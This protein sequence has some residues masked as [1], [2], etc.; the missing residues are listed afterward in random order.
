M[1]IRDFREYDRAACLA[2]FDSNVPAYFLTDERD[3]FADFLTSPMGRFYVVEDDQTNVV[4]CGG[5]YIDGSVA[6]LSWG[7]IDRRLHGRGHGRFLLQQRLRAIREDGRAQ[8]ARVRTTPS[9]QGFFEHKQFK[10]IRDGLK[11]AAPE[12]RL[13]ELTLAL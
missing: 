6:G 8:T 3:A 4:G 9:V 2:L 10:V 7:M 13:V 11:G 12:G 1:R 5:W